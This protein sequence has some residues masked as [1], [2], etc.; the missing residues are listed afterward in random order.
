MSANAKCKTKCIPVGDKPANLK[1][2]VLYAIECQ[3]CGYHILFWKPQTTRKPKFYESVM[4][5]EQKSLN[6][7]L[8]I[9][10]SFFEARTNYGHLL[11]LDQNA[12]AMS[13]EDIIEA[14]YGMLGDGEITID[15]FNK[16]TVIFNRFKP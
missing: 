12:P 16:L 11:K 14:L 15:E 10:P 13:T 4:I 2:G 5:G 1:F 8:S 3:V 6:L 9:S 7:H